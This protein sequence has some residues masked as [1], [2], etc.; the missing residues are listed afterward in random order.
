MPVRPPTL[1]EWFLAYQLDRVKRDHFHLTLDMEADVTTLA[2]DHEEAGHRL[3]VT[4][5]LVKAMAVL[6]RENPVVNRMIFRTLLGMRVLE[7]DY[8]AVN[9][10]VVLE[11]GTG[12]HLSGTVV[13][14]PGG[15][16]LEEIRGELV[17][18]RRRP[19]EDLPVGRLVYGLPNTWWR[20]LRLRLLH[21]AV[22]NLPALYE[23]AGAGALAVST[24]MGHGPAGTLV[25][26]GPTALTLACCHQ[27]EAEG[28]TYLRLGFA[29]DHAA[30]TGVQAAAAGKR[31][32]EIL[33]GTDPTY[34][35]ALG[36]GG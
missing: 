3:P 28:R 33:A 11:A 26:F 21:D 16:T 36:P 27:E 7:P 31:L 10:P 6:A 35:A 9:V 12:E 34:R 17:A 25:G 18:A 5:V 13:K 4:A 23:R 29:W 8:V 14:E 30:L 2:R 19:I 24:I 1:E 32:G 20:R 15:M 22:Q